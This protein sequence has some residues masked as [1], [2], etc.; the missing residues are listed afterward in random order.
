MWRKLSGIRND[1]HFYVP[2]IA[3]RILAELEIA[4]IERIVCHGE[5]A[6][7]YMADGYARASNGPAACM[8]Q[9]VGAA[10]L[11][12]GLQDPSWDFLPSSP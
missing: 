1:P 2:S 9:S 6:A 7:A 8:A 4:G 3:R 12:A 10:N 11:A 5:K